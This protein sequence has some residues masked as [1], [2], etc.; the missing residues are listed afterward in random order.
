MVTISLLAVLA[1]LTI[2][3]YCISRVRY[4][5]S[6]YSQMEYESMMGFNRD[7]SLKY[8]RNKMSKYTFYLV[9]AFGAACFVL[10]KLYV[11]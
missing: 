1:L 5:S 9:I 11:Q 2:S 4:Y 6:I 7:H 10:F 3:W 8:Y